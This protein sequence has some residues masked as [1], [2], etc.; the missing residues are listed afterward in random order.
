MTRSSPFAA[1]VEFSHV[2]VND[3][4]EFNTPKRDGLRCFL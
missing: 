2:L 1:S 3:I 4:G